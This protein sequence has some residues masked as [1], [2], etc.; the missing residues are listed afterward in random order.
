MQT[1]TKEFTKEHEETLNKRV[2]IETINDSTL[3]VYIGR[4]W[5]QILNL[6]NYSIDSSTN[7]HSCHD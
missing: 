4:A 5:G 1:E 6:Q 2:V 7:K 3:R